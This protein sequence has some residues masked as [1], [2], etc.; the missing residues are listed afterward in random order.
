MG[1]DLRTPSARL[2][3][4]LRLDLARHNIMTIHVRDETP[5]SRLRQFGMVV[6][7]AD[8][9]VQGA[10]LTISTIAEVT[11]MTRGAV[12]LILQSLEARGLVTTRWTKNAS[13][14]G[15]A[16]LFHLVNQLDRSRS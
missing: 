11:G 5:G 4:Q 2:A 14:R 8:L 3:F 10:P 12:E 16:K 6:V 1:T 9:A 13:G 7:L 15:R